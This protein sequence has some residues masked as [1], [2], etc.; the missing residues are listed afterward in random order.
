MKEQIRSISDAPF[1][2][3]EERARLVGL[4]ARITG[5]SEIAEDLAQETLLEAWRSEY[6]LRDESKRRQ[7]LSGIARNVCL[8][9]QRKQGRDSAHLIGLHPQPIGEEGSLIDLEDA[10]VSDL[11]IEVELERKELIELLDRA[12]T[13]LPAETRTVLVQHYIEESALAEIAARLGT[14]AS[15]VAMRL[16]RGRLVLRRVLT[17]E[18]HTEI[19]PYHQRD[20]TEMWE[21]TPLWCP[22]C[23]QRR[24]LGISIP[25][26]GK[27]YLKC[28]D[29]TPGADEALSTNELNEL[30]GMRGYK[31]IFRRLAIIGDRYYRTALRHGSIAC[32]NCGRMTRV[33]YLLRDDIPQWVRERSTLRWWEWGE[34][35]KMVCI[36][37]EHCLTSWVNTL[38]YLVLELAEAQSFLQVHPRIRTLPRQELEV[39][40][41]PALLTSLES[42]TDQGRL[43]V[44][45]DSETYEVLRIYGGNR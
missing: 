3:L 39:D 32:S 36:L 24:L 41:R 4:C 20:L 22:V 37:C 5:N 25:I 27:F 34:N 12:L 38:E 43:D 15:A 40:G 26:E 2:L 35:D 33:R 1:I 19:A 31:R 45:S 6:A 28:P 9:W 10:L 18:M 7:W 30:K 11:D 16:Q 13:L 23:G 42:V 29:C 14:N 44:I 21:E 17:N 8:R